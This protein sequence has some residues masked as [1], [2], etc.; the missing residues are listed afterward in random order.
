MIPITLELL[1]VQDQNLLE[2]IRDELEQRG[3]RDCSSEIE[4]DF[5]LLFSDGNTIGLQKAMVIVFAGNEIA[6]PSLGYVDIIPKYIM[7]T[8]SALYLVE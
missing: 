8:R 3:F 2:N 7:G 4:G 6:L 1:D 5:Q